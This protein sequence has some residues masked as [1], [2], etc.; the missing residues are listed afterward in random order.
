MPGWG[1]GA[2]PTEMD[3]GGGE[4]WGG[5]EQEGSWGVDLSAKGWRKRGRSGH[6]SAPGGE[7][8][9]NVRMSM[10]KTRN[11]LFLKENI[12]I[13]ISRVTLAKT[14]SQKCTEF[15]IYGTRRR[16]MARV[17]QDRLGGS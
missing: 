14:T 17:R 12:Y 11:L 13:Y 3:A 9:G 10:V 6:W 4:P 8:R 7:K 15:R 5:S 1:S 2:D 16:A